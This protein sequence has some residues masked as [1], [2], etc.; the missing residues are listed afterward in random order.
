MLIVDDEDPVTNIGV[1]E[2][3]GTEIEPQLDSVARGETVIT[4]ENFG[5]LLVE[6]RELTWNSSKVSRRREEI[7]INYK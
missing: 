6:A 7:S 2:D 5:E 3:R 4:K 1:C